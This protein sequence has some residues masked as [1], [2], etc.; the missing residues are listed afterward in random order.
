MNQP[1]MIPLVDLKAQYFGLKEEIDKAISDCIVEGNFIKGKIVTEFENAFSQY[2]GADYCVGCGNGTDALELIL[3]SLNIGPGDEVIVPALTW[4]ATAEAVNNVGAEPVFVDIDQNNYTIDIRKIEEK[5]TKKTKA[6]ILVH[7]YGC[8]ADL[9][10]IIRIA[11]KYG[12]FIVE[13][14]AQAHGAEYFGKKIGTYGIA[15]AFSFFPSKNLGAFGDGGAIVTNN[16]ELANSARMISNHGQLHT[17]HSHLVIGRNSRLDSIQASILKAKL[18]YLDKWNRN[19]IEASQHYISRLEGMGSIIL[20]RVEQNKTHVYHLFVIRSQKREKLI[21]V[22]NKSNISC[23]IHYP[24]PLPFLD[25]YNYKK[26]KLEDFPIA[27]KITNEILSIPIFPEITDSQ[28][29]T[30]CDHILKIHKTF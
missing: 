20:P 2:L 14:C 16:Q 13:D 3:K 5:I 23:S 30:I 7:L 25:A 9:E 17:R 26:H 1:N 11:K 6:I 27:V 19:R 24:K 8:P 12:L 15:S 18:P 10:E 4:I 29:D 28:V 22:L 21:E